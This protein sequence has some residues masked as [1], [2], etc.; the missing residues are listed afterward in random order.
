MQPARAPPG[1]Q[2]CTWMC[3][4]AL[5]MQPRAQQSVTGCQWNTDEPMQNQQQNSPDPVDC[6]NWLIELTDVLIQQYIEGVIKLRAKPPRSALVHTQCRTTTHSG[7]GFAVSWPVNRIPSTV[8]RY[9]CIYLHS[10]ACWHHTCMQ[11]L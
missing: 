7:H 9:L 4:K 10:N 6:L 11:K 8:A 1:C 3:D 5:D 2:V